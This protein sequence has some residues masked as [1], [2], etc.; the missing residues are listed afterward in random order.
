MD[1]KLNNLWF[2]QENIH[3]VPR[4]I[5]ME[6]DS[7]QLKPFMDKMK[8]FD[9]KRQ[10]VPLGL[11]TESK[12]PVELKTRFHFTLSPL[13]QSDPVILEVLGATKGQS[14]AERVFISGDKR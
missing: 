2:L 5:N 13:A 10:L 4:T 6:Y 11:A 12:F 7:R 1:K 8:R 3:D 14:K 9:K